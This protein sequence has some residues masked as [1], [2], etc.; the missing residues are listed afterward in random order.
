MRSQDEIQFRLES[1][2]VALQELGEDHYGVPSLL[3]AIEE[4][5]WTLDA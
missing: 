4:L 3:S 2:R 1:F 5:E